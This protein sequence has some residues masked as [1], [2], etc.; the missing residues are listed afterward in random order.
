MKCWNNHEVKFLWRLT[1]KPKT[2]KLILLTN[3][4]K[5]TVYPYDFPFKSTPTGWIDGFP[6][7]GVPRPR[8]NLLIVIIACQYIRKGQN[9][10]YGI[11][12]LA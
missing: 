9:H 6:I 3:I 1:L 2:D 12:S 11:V 8:N 10:L 4:K 5:K 7:K